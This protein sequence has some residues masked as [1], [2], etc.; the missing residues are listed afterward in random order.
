[1]HTIISI[2]RRVVTDR[3]RDHYGKEDSFYTAD[4]LRFPE[5]SKRFIDLRPK[6]NLPTPG[7]GYGTTPMAK[8]C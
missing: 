7:P 8:A 2:A 5:P 4:S 3:F 1:M 6:M